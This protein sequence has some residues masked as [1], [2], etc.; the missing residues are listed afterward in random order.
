VLE[1][2]GELDLATEPVLRDQLAELERDPPRRLVID[3][4]ALS[5]IDATG[6]HL[7]ESAYERILSDGTCSLE[8]RPGPRVVQRL[9][10][11]TGL[12]RSLP[13]VEQ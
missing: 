7:M 10:E 6:L 4:G 13:F 1:L 2:E 12:D 3:L 5:F 9:F 11:L 8:L